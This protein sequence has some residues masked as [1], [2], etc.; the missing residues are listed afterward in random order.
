MAHHD[1]TFRPWLH[2]NYSSSS[3]VGLEIAIPPGHTFPPPS[4][5]ELSCI[6][7]EL[8]PPPGKCTKRFLRPHGDLSHSRPSSKDRFTAA[9]VEMIMADEKMPLRNGKQLLDDHPEISDSTYSLMIPR[10]EPRRRHVASYDTRRQPSSSFSQQEGS[11]VVSSSQWD[12]QDTAWSCS[13]SCYSQAEDDEQQNHRTRRI[14]GMDKADNLNAPVPRGSFYQQQA[15]YSFSSMNIPPRSSLPPHMD[16]EAQPMS[17]RHR[18]RPPLSIFATSPAASRSQTDLPRKPTLTSRKALTLDDMIA[19]ERRRFEA[20]EF[21]RS[22][23]S[24]DNLTIPL[25]G[26]SPKVQSQ[27]QYSPESR[28][29]TIPAL[30][31][32]P[33]TLRQK[34]AS[35]DRE[36]VSVFDHS[37]DDEDMGRL[38]LARASVMS[39]LR[40]ISSP[41]NPGSPTRIS[42]VQMRTSIPNQTHVHTRMA[43]PPLV[44]PRRKRA[45]SGK[46]GHPIKS[47]FP[48]SP[49]QKKKKKKKEQTQWLSKFKSGKQKRVK[50]KGERRDSIES[51]EG[52]RES[53]RPRNGS[54]PRRFSNAIRSYASGSSAPQTPSSISGTDVMHNIVTTEARNADSPDTPIP[55]KGF[56]KIG[57]MGPALARGGVGVKDAV[58]S[59]RKGVHVKSRDERRRDKMRKK[60]VVIGQADQSPDG[61]VNNWL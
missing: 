22:I 39:N 55:T 53:E 27:N 56:M 34:H 25:Y 40:K 12:V 10:Q 50:K 45:F 13:D 60:I 15:A 33:L 18:D 35:T 5:T 2:R 41:V 21:S 54:F 28:H 6:H 1:T 52:P 16:G 3:L 20:E 31:P 51:E 23:W 49:T 57:S 14:S 61:V 58:A 26:T 37:S 32:R 36:S 11:D 59:V 30:M 47:P 29:E 7:K 4:S 48:F 42:Q 43:P 8:P 24:R 19:R 44:A 46:T 9:S 17:L 38:A